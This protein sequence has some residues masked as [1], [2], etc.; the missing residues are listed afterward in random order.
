MLSDIDLSGTYEDQGSNSSS[1]QE[2][3]KEQEGETEERREKRGEERGGKGMEEKE[4]KG[5]RERERKELDQ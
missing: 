1:L 3:G 4:G 5:G 2:I